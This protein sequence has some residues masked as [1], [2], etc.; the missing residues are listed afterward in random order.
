MGKKRDKASVGKTFVE[1]I[2][3]FGLNARLAPLG[4]QMYAADFLA[5]AKAIQPPNVPF[6]PARPYLV[7][8]ALEL[9]LKAFLSLKEYSVDKLADSKFSHNLVSLLDEAERNGLREFVKLEEDETFQ[10]RRASNYY[11][12]KVFEYPAIGEASLGYFGSPDTNILINAAEAL[13]GV[14]REPCL[15]GAQSGV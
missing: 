1:N 12:E 4:F 14:L 2:S 10:I 6:A 11:S 3:I 5:A 13:V 9:A 15:E 8:H 7:C